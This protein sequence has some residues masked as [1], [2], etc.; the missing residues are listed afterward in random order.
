MSKPQSSSLSRIFLGT[1][2]ALRALMA[3]EFLAFGLLVAHS[4]MV[5][6]SVYLYNTSWLAW[7]IWTFV[8]LTYQTG[9][10]LA[11][12]S[13]RMPWLANTGW[14]EFRI[15]V[16]LFLIAV[17]YPLA[18]DMR[19]GLIPALMLV[20]GFALLMPTDPNP[21]RRTACAIAFALAT[22]AFHGWVWPGQA[23][24]LDSIS[25]ALATIFCLGGWKLLSDQIN[26]LRLRVQ[27]QAR[28][29]EDALRHNEKLASFDELTGLAN[30]RQGNHLISGAIQRQARAQ[31][32]LVGVVLDLDFFKKINDT[33]GHGGGDEVLRCFAECLQQSLRGTDFAVRWGGEEFL[34][35]LEITSA[36]NIDPWLN[37]LHATIEAAPLLKEKP[38][39]RFTFS[40]GATAWR[41]GE[42]AQSLIERADEALYTA[43]RTGRNKVVRV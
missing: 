27:D 40:G 4:S 41:D 25:H 1:H 17:P 8:T 20:L 37:R 29:L 3:R 9:T 39:L 18:G 13:D 35:M 24:A 6:F 33:H 11:I 31:L 34:V 42:T 12:R 43:K 32:G 5:A 7:G 22:I 16:V 2:P 38:Q 19:L 15:I 28:A 10:M 26:L 14:V 30:R 21:M 36:D 23:S